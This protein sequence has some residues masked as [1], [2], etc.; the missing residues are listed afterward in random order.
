MKRSL[1]TN[2]SYYAK[3][4][5]SKGGAARAK[6]LTAS[7]R[8]AIAVKGGHAR[9]AKGGKTKEGPSDK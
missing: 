5:A 6:K 8:H 9:Q 7:E 2:M 4:F 3:K 1:E